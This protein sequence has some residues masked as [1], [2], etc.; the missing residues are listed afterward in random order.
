MGKGLDVT[1]TGRTGKNDGGAAEYS[2]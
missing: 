2:L 1:T